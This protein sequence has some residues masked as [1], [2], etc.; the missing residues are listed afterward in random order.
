MIAVGQEL[1]RVD[2]NSLTELENRP[3]LI[4]LGI[5]TVLV[6]VFATLT[7]IAGSYL[8]ILPAFFLG[9][10]YAHLV[11]LQH[12]CLHN[13]AFRS[14]A[15]NRRVGILLG[16]PLLVSFSDY[17]HSHMR[18]HKLLGTPEDREF[19][20]YNYKYLTSIR[21]LIPHLFM[22]RHYADVIV[23]IAKSVIG[24]Y[25][26]EGASPRTIARI[27]NEYRL[28]ALFLALMAAHLILVDASSITSQVP[29]F[30]KLW[31]VPFLVGVPAHALIELPEHIGCN[32]KTPNVIENTRTIKASKL[33]VWY[34]AGNNYHVEHHWLPGVPNHKFPELYKLI[35]PY[36][37]THLE[38]SYFAFYMDYFKRLY[39][40][41]FAREEVKP[42]NKTRAASGS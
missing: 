26:Q 30:F 12:Q 28:M 32:T 6:I 37:V 36:G 34:T 38:E 5:A 33:A 42:Q 20:K 13:T 22:V 29:V 16:I 11:E 10:T 7:L 18:H 2:I 9:L 1:D 23:F 3:F 41:D 17:Q 14:T 21:A 31:F 15:W 27:R 39:K 40:G 25:T 4:K 24:T 8:W 19:F 35:Q